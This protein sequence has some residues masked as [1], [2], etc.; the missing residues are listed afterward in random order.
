MDIEA[1]RSSRS[2]ARSAQ[3]LGVVSGLVLVA[4]LMPWRASTSSVVQG[5]GQWTPQA[6]VPFLVNGSQPATPDRYNTYN[7][8]RV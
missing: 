5:S 3:V 1:R 2:L 8:G 4:A 7:F 6:R